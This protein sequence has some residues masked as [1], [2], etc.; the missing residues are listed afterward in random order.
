[1][2]TTIS[3]PEVAAPA[4]PAAPVEAE[5]K[6]PKPIDRVAEDARKMIMGPTIF[7]LAIAAVAAILYLYN[8]RAPK[9]TP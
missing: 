7:A 6:P 8:L 1:M 9:L 3:T 2:A 4:Q 5:A